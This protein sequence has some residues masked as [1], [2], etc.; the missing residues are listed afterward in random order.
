LKT[1]VKAWLGGDHKPY[2]IYF[3]TESNDGS[4]YDTSE[5][6]KEGTPPV[7]SVTY[8]LPVK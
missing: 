5:A 2:G 6:L 3:R 7:L 1:A 4:D 8:T